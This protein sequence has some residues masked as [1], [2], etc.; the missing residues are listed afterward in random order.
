MT[1]LL[2]VDTHGKPALVFKQIKDIYDCE[3]AKN[4]SL[5]VVNT[6]ENDDNG[7]KVDRTCLPI[8]KGGPIGSESETCVFGSH[9][10]CDERNSDLDNDLS[11]SSMTLTQ[12][13]E[14]CKKKKRKL[15]KFVDLTKE[16][17]EIFSSGKQ[18]YQDLLLEEDDFDLKEPLSSWK[19]R[20]TKNRKAKKRCFSERVSTSSQSAVSEAKS[21]LVL[22]DWGFQQSTRD[23]TTLIKV[24]VEVAE[25]N[26]SDSQ[27]FD[28]CSV[29]CHEQVEVG[30][31][32]C[33]GSQN[34]ICVADDSSAGCNEQDEV[35]ASDYSDS[36]GDADNCTMSCNEQVEVH[37]PDYSA[38][39]NMIC[40]ADDCSLDCSEQVGFCE[41]V[42][43]EM[44]KN[45]NESVLGTRHS[46][47]YA[48]EPRQCTVN[49]I[50][51]EYN[52][53]NSLPNVGPTIAETL[54]VDDP[55]KADNRAS[56][57]SVSE[58]RNEGFIAYPP[59]QGIPP[60]TFSPTKEHNSTPASPVSEIK[61]EGHVMQLL[62]PDISPQSLSPTKE[63]NSAA[64]LP[65]S[66]FKNEEYVHLLAQDIFP[67]TL[68]PIKEHGSDTCNSSQSYSFNSC[69]G[70]RIPDAAIDNSLNSCNGVQVPDAAIDNSP[71][72]C[73][74]VQ[75]PDAAIHNCLYYVEPSNGGVALAFEDD[76]TGNLPSTLPDSATILPDGK[77]SSS[78]NS[79]PCLSATGSLVPKGD[80]LPTTEVK[81][82]LMISS[83]DTA[84]DCS[85]SHPCDTTFKELTSAVTENCEH[86]ELQHGPEKLFSTRKVG[87]FCCVLIWLV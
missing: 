35:L 13:K 22:S 59:T 40:I 23:L 48:E 73:N 18:E 67:Q 52:Q 65:G 8:T 19:S 3:D 39:Q 32:D 30:G 41:V 31:S 72:S 84:R 28:D 66:E 78:W 86:S 71:N 34:V 1:K 15:S 69:N 24:E 16:D 70:V 14:R 4:H 46:I 64:L 38:T 53:L 61:D 37:V 36:Q 82:I 79:S 42:V 80:D 21:K 26:C 17:V 25:P 11:F 63:H 5:S 51:H 60:L 81:Q 20:L 33:S 29:V 77:C 12:L 7:L 68:S 87:F 10:H 2:N 83:S 76:H 9:G 50:S 57:L 54:E 47:V 45:D 75:V 43:S 58:F 85:Y 74:G 49:K 27:G 56:H 62:T 55:E 44:P 6:T